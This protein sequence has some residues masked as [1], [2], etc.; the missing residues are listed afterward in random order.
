MIKCLKYNNLAVGKDNYMIS[1]RN[2]KNKRINKPI[3]SFAN[4]SNVREK[5]DI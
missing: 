5:E 4:L 1:K 2:Q 3:H